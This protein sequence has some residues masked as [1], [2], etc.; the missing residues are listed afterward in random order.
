V[1]TLPP[2]SKCSSTQGRIAG[3]EVLEA[4]GALIEQAERR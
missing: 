4:L 2:K 1:S 3:R